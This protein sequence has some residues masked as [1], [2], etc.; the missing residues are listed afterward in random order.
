MSNL[1]MQKDAATSYLVL[2]LDKEV[3]KQR[4]SSLWF[5][6]YVHYEYWIA[7]SSIFD[8]DDGSGLLR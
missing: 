4:A 2:T 1:V 3:K 8:Q 5:W 6:V 7:R